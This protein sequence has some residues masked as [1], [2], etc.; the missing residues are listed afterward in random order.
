[1]E[2]ADCHTEAEADGE[3]GQ[4]I[5]CCQAHEVCPPSLLFAGII[6]EFA[7]ADNRPKRMKRPADMSPGYLAEAGLAT[8]TLKEA[9]KRDLVMSFSFRGCTRG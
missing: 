9:A 3:H 5:D 4:A 6:V 1:M 7:E 2:E 8:A